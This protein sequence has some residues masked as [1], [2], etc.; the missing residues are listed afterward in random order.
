MLIS[1]AR[2]EIPISTAAATAIGITMSAVAVLLISC[3]R[4]AVSAK[5]PASSA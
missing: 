3:P 2:G 4:T 1:T 5:S